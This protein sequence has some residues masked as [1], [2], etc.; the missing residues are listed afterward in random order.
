MVSASRE[1]KEEI[2]KNH[3]AINLAFKRLGLILFEIAQCAIHDSKSENGSKGGDANY[4]TNSRN[5][6]IHE[7]NYLCRRKNAKT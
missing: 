6:L 4:E 2:Q 5:D 7:G 1:R 3:E